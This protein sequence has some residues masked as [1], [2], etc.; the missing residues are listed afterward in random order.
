MKKKL[1]QIEWLQNEITKDKISLEQ[2]KSRLI[3]NIKKLKKED[4]IP[5]PPQ[6]FTLWQR[7][8]KVL[9]G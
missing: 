7:I 5:K 1:T 6:K 9:M 3:E 2:E 8:R 4:V